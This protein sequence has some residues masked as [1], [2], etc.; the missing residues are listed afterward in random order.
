MTLAAA[1]VRPIESPPPLASSAAGWREELQALL[2]TEGGI[3]PGSL[4]GRIRPWLAAR[5]S[6]IQARFEADN[7]AEVVVYG[8]SQLIDAVVQCLLD[9]AVA[10]VFP[11]ANPTA[12][13]R[14][15]VVAIGG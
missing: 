2:T 12:G 9:F 10:R 15:A 11:L 5:Q 1:R 7:D 4:V 13:E 6:E 8:A 14:F 3:E